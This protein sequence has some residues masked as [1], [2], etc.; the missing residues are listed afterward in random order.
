MLHL[1]TAFWLA[2]SPA[3]ANE[4]SVGVDLGQVDLVAV[5]DVGPDVVR[6]PAPVVVAPAPVVVRRPVHYR[7]VRAAP[8]VYAAPRPVQVVHKPA[9]V[10]HK[11][12]PVVV[13]HR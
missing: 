3:Q 4:V 7:V 12:A 13:H 2:A 8:V 11:P 1:L 10:V 9:P 6:R 5:F